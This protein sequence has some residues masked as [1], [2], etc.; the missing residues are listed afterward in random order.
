MLKGSTIP[1]LAKIID[2]RR[3]GWWGRAFK[4]KVSKPPPDHNQDERSSASR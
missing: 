4:E 3:N 1:G 2:H